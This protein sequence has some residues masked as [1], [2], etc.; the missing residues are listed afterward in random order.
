MSDKRS[1]E[2]SAPKAVTSPSNAPENTRWA[3]RRSPSWAARSSRSDPT[4]P[5]QTPRAEQA[6]PDRDRRQPARLAPMVIDTDPATPLGAVIVSSRVH[7]ILTDFPWTRRSMDG[8]GDDERA[9]GWKSDTGD[10]PAV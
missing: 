10:V 2:A 6:S 7:V 4:K 8:R 1:P 3:P 5:W 9:M